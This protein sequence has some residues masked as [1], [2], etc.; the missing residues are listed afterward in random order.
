MIKMNLEE[1]IERQTNKGYRVTF[2]NEL[3]AIKATI[4]KHD[5]ERYTTHNVVIPYEYIKGKP[6]EVVDNFIES[7]ILKLEEGN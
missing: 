4:T 1:F 5:L 7:E 6:K 3:G 2:E